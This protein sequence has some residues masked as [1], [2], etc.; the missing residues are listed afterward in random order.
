MRKKE[1]KRKEIE[2]KRGREKMKR[3]EDKVCKGW[4]SERG[5]EGRR[6]VMEGG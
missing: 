1:R 6:G 2:N 3:R 5:G 4:E